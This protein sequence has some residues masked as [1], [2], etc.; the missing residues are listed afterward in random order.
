MIA[1]RVSLLCMDLI[2]MNAVGCH[3]I[4]RAIVHYL[5]PTPRTP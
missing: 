3:S 4:H 1:R 2:L 5:T